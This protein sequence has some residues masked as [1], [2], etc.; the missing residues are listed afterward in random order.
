MAALAEV[1]AEAAPARRRWGTIVGAILASLAVVAGLTW[2]VFTSVYSPIELNGSWGV[3]GAMKSAG[4]GMDV[5]KWVLTGPAN[6]T[7]EVLIGIRNSGPFPVRLLGDGFDRDI[8]PLA[9]LSWAPAIS[10]RDSTALGHPDEVRPFPV[11]LQP[12]DEV[13]VVI[14]AFKRG[15]L[16]EPG[17]G[18][19]AGTILGMIPLRW[20][21]LGRERTHEFDT[22]KP[23]TGMKPIVLCPP[24]DINIH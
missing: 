22:A 24:S 23:D 16:Y 17:G 11:T 5:T 19:S 8:P 7:G 21:M 18:A 6:G 4:D 12:G 15:C 1:E 9:E 20:S 10:P 13:T 14:K 3:R 2:A